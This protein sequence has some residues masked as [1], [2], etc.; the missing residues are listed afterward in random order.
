MKKCDQNEKLVLLLEITRVVKGDC[1]KGNK[2]N[3]VSLTEMKRSYF[4]KESE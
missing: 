2:R 4:M 1:I 3:D